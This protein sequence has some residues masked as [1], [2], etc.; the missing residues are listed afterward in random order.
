MQEE[1]G[2]K[3]VARGS[4]GHGE[5]AGGGDEREERMEEK[6]KSLSPH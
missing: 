3:M 1:E 2:G 6:I 4:W 5:M